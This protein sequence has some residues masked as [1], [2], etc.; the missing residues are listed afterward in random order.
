VDRKL[1]SVGVVDLLPGLVMLR[2]IPGPVRSD[3]GPEVVA[4]A[5]RGWIAAVG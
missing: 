4:K 5:V 1:G 3:N 2:G